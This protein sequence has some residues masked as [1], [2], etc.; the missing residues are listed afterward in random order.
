MHNTHN[1]STGLTGFTFLA[2][3]LLVIW[4]QSPLT[5]ITMAGLS[6]LDADSRLEETVNSRPYENFTH[7]C[8]PP[9]P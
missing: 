7:A 3:S 1:P 6:R 9:A 8:Y 2:P 5:I 4:A